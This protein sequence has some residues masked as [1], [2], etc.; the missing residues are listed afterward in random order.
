MISRSYLMAVYDPTHTSYYIKCMGDIWY[1]ENTGVVASVLRR[2]SQILENE[3]A[4]SQW[5]IVALTYSIYTYITHT[6]VT[7]YNIRSQ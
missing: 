3:C 1:R 5:E 7:V 6:V 4:I 2:D